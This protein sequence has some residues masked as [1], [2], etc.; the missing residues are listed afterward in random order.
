[1]L[2]PWPRRGLQEALRDQAAQL[3]GAV[4][5]SVGS[6]LAILI[7]RAAVAYSSRMVLARR[8]TSL[9]IRVRQPRPPPRAFEGEFVGGQGFNQ[10]GTVQRH[11]EDLARAVLRFALPPPLLLS[12]SLTFSVGHGHLLQVGDILFQALQRILICSANRRRRN[13]A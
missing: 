5:S 4:G 11:G 7:L 12:A 10:E 3:L 9:A 13:G 8:A 1:M 6:A 2:Q